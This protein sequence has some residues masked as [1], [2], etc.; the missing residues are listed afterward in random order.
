M[1]DQM[2]DS[3]RVLSGS[4]DRQPSCIKQNANVSLSCLVYNMGRKKHLVA[5]AT[6]TGWKQ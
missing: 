3:V 1:S 5:G 4:F 6:L 2:H